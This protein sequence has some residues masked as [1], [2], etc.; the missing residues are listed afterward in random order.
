MDLAMSK[1]TFSGVVLAL[2]VFLAL[3]T[4][5]FAGDGTCG[6]CSQVPYG[7]YTASTNYMSPVGYHCW[8]TYHATGVWPDRAEVQLEASAEGRPI[9]QRADSPEASTPVSYRE[10]APTGPFPAS[11]RF[12]SQHGY[13]RWRQYG[14]AGA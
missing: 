1:A 11:R 3:G 9:A 8:Q 4:S 6:A 10:D 14:N 7:S 2:A 12:M 5:S 13:D